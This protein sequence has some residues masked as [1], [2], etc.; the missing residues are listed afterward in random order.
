M[1]MKKITCL[2]LLVFFLHTVGCKSNKRQNESFM[3]RVASE[4][5]A[6]KIMNAPNSF[7]HNEWNVLSKE[8]KYVVFGQVIQNLPESFSEH[9]LIYRFLTGVQGAC[10]RAERNDWITW[11]NEQTPNSVTWLQYRK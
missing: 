6:S 4:S 11:Y 3:P 1:A 7:D 8:D 5:L 9:D 10:F 2:L